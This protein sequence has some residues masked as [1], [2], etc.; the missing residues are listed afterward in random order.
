MKILIYDTTLRDGSQ[1]EGISFSVEDKIRIARR[2]DAFGM[3]YIE[4]GWPGAAP[5]DTEFF[6]R[7]RDIPL[8]HSRLAAFGS[9]RRSHVACESDPLLAEL[10]AAGTPVV[11]IVGKASA[12]HVRETLRV[13]PEEALAM[14]RDTVAYLKA[15]GREV[16]YDPEH[17]FDGYKEDRGFTLA[18]LQAAA[19]AG[20]D[21]L[22]LC[23][24]NGGTLPH[25]ISEIVADVVARF[26]GL[27]IGMH[28]HNDGDCG[29]ANALAAVRAGATHV[30]GTVNGYGERTGN[31][32]ILTIAANLRLK[33]GYDV[34]SEEAMSDL[35]RL[36]AFVDETANV[37]PNPR[38]PYVGRNAFTHKAGLHADA[39]SKAPTAYDHIDPTVV[40]NA[41]RLLVSELSG[42]A[43]IAQK[44]A[45]LGYV[46]DKRAPETRAVLSEVTAREH[47]G[48]SYEG[49]EASFELLLKKA[50]GRYR[51]LFD[52]VAFRVLVEKRAGDAE[53]ITEAT[54]RLRVNGEE[55]LTVA[56]GDG[57]VHA[58]DGALRAGLLRFYP[59]LGSI[60]LTD[61][62]VRVV[63]AGEGTASKVRTIVETTSDHGGIWSTVGASTNIIEASWEAIVDAM[64]FGLLREVG[65]K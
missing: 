38:L 56:E 57:P 41:R 22:C 10:L 58:L 19:D 12:W 36:S 1:G 7:M 3:D 21:V 46:L 6:A 4:G 61:F 20:V 14:I 45:D 17:F 27:T 64:E 26:P 52:M 48:Y 8:E 23:D 40:G 51:K 24:T 5:K 35:T 62:K 50:T 47:Q 15:H 44:A 30:Q 18:A 60:R 33:M 29:T 59:E 49:A 9:T 13:P 31:A 34:L 54:L 25:E 37:T 11:T 53:P 39:I 63:T 42:G 28:P 43:T 32:N 55:F 65:S 16:V 2:L